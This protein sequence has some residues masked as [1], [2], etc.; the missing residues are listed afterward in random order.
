MLYPQDNPHRTVMNLSGLWKFSLDIDDNGE[1]KCWFEGL[2]SSRP[3]G[4][5]GSWNEQYEDTMFYMGTAWYQTEFHTP[6]QMR[7]QRLVLRFGAAGYYTHVWLDGEPL[8]THEGAS[9][10]FEYDITRRARPGQQ[11]KLVV[12]INNRLG[13]KTIPPGQ[14]ELSPAHA[15][16]SSFI[17]EAISNFAQYVPEI[18]LL[19]LLL[20][21]REQY[22]RVPFDFL[23]FAG[24]HRPVKLYTTPKDFIKTIRVRTDI[25]RSGATVVCEVRAEGKATSV[26]AVLSRGDATFRARASLQGGVAT[27]KLAVPKPDLWHPDSPHLYH[28]VVTLVRKAT[29][30]DAY[31][32]D[33]GIRTVSVT[34]KQ[35][36]LN[37]RP[38]YLN[39]ACKHEDFPIIGRGLNEAM[40]VKDFSLMKWLGANSFRTS[41]YPYAEEYLMLADHMGFLVIDEMPTVGLDYKMYNDEILNKC[42]DLLTELIERDANHPSVIMWSIANEPDTFTESAAEFFGALK[43]HAK[44]LDPSRPVT[45]AAMHVPKD[46]TYDVVD[47]ISINRYYGW[48]FDPGQLD[49]AARKLSGELDRIH[50]EHK[51]PV[52]VSEFGA[53]S[54]AGL[55]S[56]PPEIFTEEY[57][58][59]MLKAY[60][61]VIRSKD[62]TV[63]EH[64]WN[65]ADFKTPQNYTRTVL[66]RKG[67]FTRERHPKL[68]AHIVRQIWQS[69]K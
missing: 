4:V 58:A 12:K 25:N 35:I 18:Q 56:D 7:G 51:K 49:L 31:H 30:V 29:A 57:Q 3:I 33:I 20:K 54:V 27:V 17:S 32:M 64:I 24:I 2:P 42:K 11:H 26:E 46:H 38:I 68:A 19:P 41:H 10:P 9:L 22:P 23:P 44:Q 1:D 5:P 61:D 43:A 47:V 6:P 60:I 21:M 8:G 55:H 36:L 66:N 65:F 53:D 28:L 45:L 62:F 39:G 15:S 13:P 16:E 69:S 48:Y 40:L 59:A 50:A 67:L 63:G 37:G 52:L 14:L 34:E